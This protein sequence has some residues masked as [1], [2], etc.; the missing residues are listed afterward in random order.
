M[1][2][3]V[4]TTFGRLY[5]WNN[6]TQTPY[7]EGNCAMVNGSAG[8][9]FTN[10]N[11]ESISFFSPDLCRTMTLRYSGKSLVNN[12]LGNK[13]IVDDYMLDNGKLVLRFQPGNN[14]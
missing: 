7:F 5:S 3:G 10:I 9:F 13:Y 11:N 4:N 8:E 1:G 14:L 2:T 6:W 12:I